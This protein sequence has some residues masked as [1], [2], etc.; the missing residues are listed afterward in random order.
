MRLYLFSLT[1]ICLLPS[2]RAGNTRHETIFD[3]VLNMAAFEA[4]VPQN[5]KFDGVVYQ[6]SSCNPIATSVFRAYSPDGLTEIRRYPPMD[7]K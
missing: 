2:I 7:W 4:N 3:P 6:G 5:W 1:A